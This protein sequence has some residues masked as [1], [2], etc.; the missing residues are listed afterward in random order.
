MW[1]TQRKLSALL[2]LPWTV[3]TE[4]SPDGYLVA[5]VAELPSV[6]ATGNS[7]KELASELFEAMEA[8]LTAMLENGDTVPLPPGSKAPWD[9]DAE[10]GLLSR[11]VVHNA[12]DAWDVEPSADRD[13]PVAGTSRALEVAH[14][15][16]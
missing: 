13:R 14:A 10:N 6:V 11:V 8:L 12:G 5:R 4:P 2:T 3:T 16:A 9:T 7:D 1:S 15:A